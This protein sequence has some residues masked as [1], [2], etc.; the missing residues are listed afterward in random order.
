[1]SQPNLF[2]L[3]QDDGEEMN[4]ERYHE[5]DPPRWQKGNRPYEPDDRLLDFAR[6]GD[7][8]E[9]NGIAEDESQAPAGNT[10]KANPIVRNRKPWEV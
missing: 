4:G 6:T 5:P 10:S 9:E 8:R 2:R 7:R 1:M 3:I